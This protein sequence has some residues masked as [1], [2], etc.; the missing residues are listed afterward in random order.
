MSAYCATK[1]LEGKLLLFILLQYAKDQRHDAITCRYV[2]DDLRRRRKGGRQR[3][4]SI[5]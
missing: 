2:P 5:K 4:F 1:N 3:S